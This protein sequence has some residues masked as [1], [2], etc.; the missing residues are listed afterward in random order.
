MSQR[1]DEGLESVRYYNTLDYD[2]VVPE[3]DAARPD[4]VAHII[5]PLTHCALKR[6]CDLYPNL[7]SKQR[8]TLEQATQACADSRKGGYRVGREPA[9]IALTYAGLCF[10]ALRDDDTPYGEVRV[11]DA[12]VIA[13]SRYVVEPPARAAQTVSDVI[14][15]IIMPRHPELRLTNPAAMVAFLSDERTPTTL[16]GLMGGGNGFSDG[17]KGKNADAVTRPWRDDP[18]MPV[19]QCGPHGYLTATP[20][21]RRAALEHRHRVADSATATFTEN[22]LFSLSMRASSGCPMRRLEFRRDVPSLVELGLALTDEQIVGL[23][24]GRHAI[25]ERQVMDGVLE[26]FVPA[27]EYYRIT[28]DGLAAVCRSLAIAVEQLTADDIA[29]A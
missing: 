7:I 5:A 12:Q 2:S 20:E 8:P 29:W 26:G 16:R 10:E 19:L 15:D 24:T 9:T 25:A 1:F 17:I 13:N 27:G 3:D 22:G 21:V 18:T 14:A 23:T 28:C 11:T 4:Y 6:T